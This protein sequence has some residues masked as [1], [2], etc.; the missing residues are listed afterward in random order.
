MVLTLMLI[1]V[2]LVLFSQ[3]GRVLYV[4]RPVSK[5]LRDTAKARKDAWRNADAVGRERIVRLECG[6]RVV[7]RA[8]GAGALL[9]G[10]F[11]TTSPVLALACAV[12]AWRTIR[13]A[14][15]EMR[16]ACS[17]RSTG[18]EDEPRHLF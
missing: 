11:A 6:W 18:G 4:E 2:S 3:A 14:R 1:V 15:Q 5:L 16:D 7:G 8:A 17:Y 13:P 10:A 12:S 9:A